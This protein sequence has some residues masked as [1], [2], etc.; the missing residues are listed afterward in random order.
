MKLLFLGDSITCGVLVQEGF[1]DLVAKELRC[2]VKNYGKSGTRIAKQTS[3]SDDF[4]FDEDFLTRAKTMDKNA[5]FVFVF[6]GTNDYGHGDATMGT[7]GDKKENTFLG[8]LRL[9]LDYLQMVYGKEKLCFILPLPRFGMNSIYGE[10]GIKLNKK[11]TS[12]YPLQLYI[13]KEKSFLESQGVDYLDLCD[14]FI[15]PTTNKNSE[16]FVDGIHP[17]QEGHKRIAAAVCAY[18]SRKN[19]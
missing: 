15:E 3:S 10:R 19:F 7:I 6:G 18:L 5:D 1:V 4:S 16:L 8:A 9:L 14:L 13:Q 2:E 17:N 11:Y 12:L